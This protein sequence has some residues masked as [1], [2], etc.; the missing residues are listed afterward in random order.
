MR[1]NIGFVSI[2]GVTSGGFSVYR[3]ISL[4]ATGQA[5]KTSAGQVFGWHLANLAAST[6]YVKF[7]DK[8]SAPTVGTDTPLL[9]LAL[10]ASAV[11]TVLS[12]IGIPFSLGIGIGAV[13]GVADN[14]TTAPSAN[15]VIVN[16]F[17][18]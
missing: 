15:E 8:A 6:R 10:P 11:V 12:E 3:N 17:Y 9:T 18:K 16:I 13:T 7:Y 4:L 5:V 1:N 14:N 2:V